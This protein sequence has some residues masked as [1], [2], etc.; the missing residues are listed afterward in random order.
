MSKVIVFT[1]LTLDGV[2]QA[3]ARPDED[4]R[5]GFAYGGW[6]APYAAMAQAGESMPTIGALLLGRRTY[7]DFYA[8]WPRRK[9]SPFSAL[10]DNM[11][12]YVA[13]TT[14]SEPLLWINSTLLKGDAA[15]TVARLKQE[16]STDF[17]IMGSGELVQSLM[18][19]NLI[20]EYVLLIHPLVLGAGRRLF[21]EGGIFG[22][23]RLVGVRTTTNGVVIATYQPA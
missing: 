20:D 8:V 19:A 16:S 14:L 18:R 10:L 9:D 6:A 13:S 11:Q 17:V 12:K 2:M 1:N 4:R 5:G 23:L 22:T 21:P 7:E 3:P 15:E